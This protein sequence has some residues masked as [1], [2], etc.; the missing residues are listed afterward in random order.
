MQSLR[1]QATENEV[2]LG[3]CINYPAAGIVERV[4]SDW[5][6]IWID[7]QHGEHDYQ[8]ILA[9]VRSAEAAQTATLVRVPGHDPGW[10]GRIL[11]TGASGVIVPQVDT[12]E[13]VERIVAAAKFAP[14]GSRSYGGRRPID[15]GGRG[16]AEK[17]NADTLLV[18][19]IESHTAIQN[20][21]DILQV[22][23]VDAFFF[24]P[25]DV[26]MIDGLPMEKPKQP[27]LYDLV[28]ETLS[29][30]AKKHDVICGG[31]FGQP[32]D[33]AKVVAMGYTLLGVGSDS[34]FLSDISKE[35]RAQLD[36]VLGGASL[37]PSKKPGSIY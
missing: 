1:V 31:A 5:D 26:A 19:Q 10:I 4:A 23:G 32:E 35:R 3:F 2:L 30:I 16:Y 21:D 18:V 24:G 8:S 37:K 11:D 9:C 34:A 33:A 25:D 6:W 13:Q 20:A 12:R 36:K 27:G 17:A 15:L 29:D 28:L 7:G 14:L 22:P